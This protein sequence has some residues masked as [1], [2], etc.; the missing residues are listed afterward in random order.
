MPDRET[1]FLP[2]KKSINCGGRLVSFDE[3]KIMGIL[4]LT[5]DSFY[6]GG[7]LSDENS[8]LQQ[9]EQMLKQGATFLDVG[10]YST[11]PGADVVSADEEKN[12]VIPAIEILVRDFTEAFFSID[13][14]RS[15]VAR[16]AI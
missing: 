15:D 13:T 3:P 9:A 4:N 2:I 6:D 7:K 14:Y 8:L 11:R 5:P 1:E 10:G 12:R 16:E